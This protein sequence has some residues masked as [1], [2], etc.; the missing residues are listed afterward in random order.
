M[1]SVVESIAVYDATVPHWYF[2][3]KVFQGHSHSLDTD[4]PPKNKGKKSK[5]QEDD[6]YWYSFD[7]LILYDYEWGCRE[8]AGESIASKLA[9]TDL[10]AVVDEGTSKPGK[11][12]GKF[13]GFVGLQDNETPAAE[14]EDEEDYGGLMVRLIYSQLSFMKLCL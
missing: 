11:S 9:D 12:T 10:N 14:E 4:M 5:K 3:S 13:G 2:H 1:K 6:E 8:K 7:Y